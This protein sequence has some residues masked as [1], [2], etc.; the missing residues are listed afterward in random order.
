MYLWEDTAHLKLIFQLH[1]MKTV[2]EK[3]IV[4]LTYTK[5]L[6]KFSMFEYDVIHEMIQMFAMRKTPTHKVDITPICPQPDS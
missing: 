2:F 5:L 6:K 3:Q 1:K 4:N